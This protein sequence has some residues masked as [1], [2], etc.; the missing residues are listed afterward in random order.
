MSALEQLMRCHGGQATHKQAFLAAGGPA[1]MASL[2]AHDALPL[3]TRARAAGEYAP[4]RAM[5]RDCLMTAVA[6]ARRRGWAWSVGGGRGGGV[7]CMDAPT[8][9]WMGRIPTEFLRFRAPTAVW[10]RRTRTRAIRRGMRGARR[11]PAPADGV[12]MRAALAACDL[13]RAQA[14]CCIT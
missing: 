9:A 4:L 6:T 5:A 3:L 12:S 2:A 1:T 13:G 11:A 7:R 10:M 8:C 14:C